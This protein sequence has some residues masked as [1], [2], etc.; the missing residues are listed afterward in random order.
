MGDQF[1]DKMN[2]PTT[3][4]PKILAIT[5]KFRLVQTGAN[6]FTLEQRVGVDAMRNIRWQD[7]RNNGAKLSPQ[8]IVELCKAYNE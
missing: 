1:T 5:A 4:G 6:C 3:H 7:T 8:D 2:M